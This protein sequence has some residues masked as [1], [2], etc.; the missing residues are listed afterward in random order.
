MARITYNIDTIDLAFHIWRKLGRHFESA[1]K[2][3]D[4]KG[5][6]ISKQTLYNWASEYGWNERA[7]SV[8]EQE[9]KNKGKRQSFR[10]QALSDLMVQKEKY[11]KYFSTLATPDHRAMYAYTGIL[12]T[13]SEIEKSLHETGD[14]LFSAAPVMEEFIKYLNGN[15]RDKEFREKIMDQIDGFLQRIM[16]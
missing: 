4:K 2:E 15:V 5:Y 16:P 11:D 1:L 3:L 14:V 8:D 7:D 12:K 6:V 10:Q 13:I 9:A